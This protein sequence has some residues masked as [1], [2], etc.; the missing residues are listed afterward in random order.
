MM[1]KFFTKRKFISLFIALFFTIVLTENPIKEVS[2]YDADYGVSSYDDGY[3]YLFIEPGIPPKITEYFFD[4]EDHILM[5]SVSSTVYNW[6]RFQ[7]FAVPQ[8]AIIESTTLTVR[9]YDYSPVADVNYRIQ[10][11]DE[12]NAATPTGYGDWM[13]RPKTSAYKDVILGSF[14]TNYRYEITGLKNIIQEIVDR[15]GWTLGNSLVLCSEASQDNWPIACYSY[16]GGEVVGDWTYRPHLRVKYSMPEKQPPTAD[17]TYSP[18]SPTEGQMISFDASGSTDTD[19]TITDY[20]W[21]FGNGVIG[22]GKTT[23]HAYSSSNT[24]SVQLMVTDNEGLTDQTTKDVIVSILIT[25]ADGDG[26]GDNADDFPN[27]PSE[28]TD[29]DGDGVGDNADVK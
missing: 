26:V 25:D 10:A 8:G 18:V 22:T 23:T 1:S 29:T 17:F 11:F 9:G 13:N 15:P 3:L 6:F 19:G 12:D 27:D 14:M 5:V 2:A 24:F 4:S 16:E 20:K 7:N 21:E 28:H